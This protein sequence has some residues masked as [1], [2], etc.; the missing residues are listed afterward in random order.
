MSC[1]GAVCRRA[2]QAAAQAAALELAEQ[3]ATG[4]G[5]GA[6]PSQ[7][8][9]ALAHTAQS[10]TMSVAA[11]AALRRARST[12]SRV[13]LPPL[14]GIESHVLDLLCDLGQGL[15]PDFEDESAHSAYHAG[16]TALGARL[17]AGLVR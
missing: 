4:N 5:V 10:S 1:M 9:A 8:W 2:D 16:L 3:A 13:R 7:P 6:V 14:A 15:P 12:P 17:A 11:T